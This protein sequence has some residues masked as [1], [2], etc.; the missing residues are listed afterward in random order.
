V[1]E[2]PDS[3][4]V[5]QHLEAFGEVAR[6]VA[7]GQDVPESLWETIRATW[8]G[9]NLAERE[10]VEQR[11]RS[12]SQITSSTKKRVGYSIFAQPTVG[13]KSVLPR[14]TVSPTRGTCSV[15]PNSATLQ[16][17]ATDVRAVPARLPRKEVP[18]TDP[19][20]TWLRAQYLLRLQGAALDERVK[21]GLQTFDYE[22]IVRERDAAR[23][24]AARLTLERDEAVAALAESDRGRADQLRIIQGLRARLEG[25]DDPR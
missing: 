16:G 23:S 7:S 17:R 5:R 4:L 20:L 12:R 21:A 11:A 1:N 25:K 15:S 14:M 10:A 3:P 6:L 9:M 24:E 2:S 19:V 13:G 22:Q 18:V 8:A